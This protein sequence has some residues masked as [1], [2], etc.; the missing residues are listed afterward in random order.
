MQL[1][2]KQKPL[3]HVLGGESPLLRFHLVRNAPDKV[4][5]PLVQIQLPP[6]LRE[7]A[8]PHRGP[9]VHTAAVRL[10][11]PG[12]QVQQGGFSRAVAAHNA[13]AVI[14]QDAVRKMG[15]N[16]F[17]VE[18]LGYVLQL[19]NFLPKTAGGGGQPHSL[20]R[21]RRVLIFQGFVPLNPIPALG[22]PGAAAPHNPLPLH[23]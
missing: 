3:H 1:R 18:G 19:N 10:Q 22:A 15:E 20:V 23:L 21:L 7:E 6:L 11:P 12:N 5:Y 8:D 13:D 17:S 16:C 9:H 4:V 2:R 14:P